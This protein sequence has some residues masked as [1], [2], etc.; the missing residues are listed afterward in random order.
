M[1]RSP[2]LTASRR[3][4][5]AV[6]L[7]VALVASTGVWSGSVLADRPHKLH[8]ESHRTVYER[9]VPPRVIAHRGASHAA[10]ENTF[11][12]FRKAIKQGA[13][14]IEMD[15]QRTKDKRLVLFHDWNLRRTTNVEK[16]FPKLK[17]PSV[18]DLK[19]KKLRKLDAGRWKGKKWNNT[20]IPTLSRVL[21]LGK[22]RGVK[23]LVEL[24]NP[25][26]YPGI[27]KKTLKMLR[28]R[29]LIRKGH[30]DRVQLQSFNI[31]SMRRA[32]K[33]SRKVDIGLLYPDPP[34]TLK[35][36]EWAQNINGYHREVE[37]KYIHRCQ[38]HGIKVFVWTVNGKGS[39]KRAIRMDA[40]G[41]IT[42]RPK[43]TRRIIRR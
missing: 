6:L 21:K 30:Q 37:R 18:G 24:K 31:P 29:K 9:G 8:D 13:D 1:Y 5:I 27:V 11:P 14:W 23:M 20:R 10:P 39:I 41:I 40:N 32:A 43:R 42:D 3:P 7:T 15:V 17:S 12:A 35:K 19:Y 38:K 22:R 33:R 25:G 28:K 26:R 2:R 34:V 16:K 36:H 4:V